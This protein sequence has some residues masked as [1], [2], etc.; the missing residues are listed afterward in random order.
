M[1]L[2]LGD[3][4]GDDDTC[5][6]P[7][8]D[9][10]FRRALVMSDWL[11]CYQYHLVDISGFLWKYSKSSLAHQ[12]TFFN[13]PSSQNQALVLVLFQKSK[14]CWAPYLVVDPPKSIPGSSISSWFS[15]AL[16]EHP[17]LPSSSALQP[18]K[19]SS[20]TSFPTRKGAVYHTFN[21]LSCSLS[22]CT[23]VEIFFPDT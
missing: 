11:R 7:R 12:R 4:S 5:T 23:C 14:I 1:I 18:R 16:T 21:T 9:K 22:S 3:D 8:A 15:S 19:S 20:L 2:K 10:T 13:C 6:P 17:D